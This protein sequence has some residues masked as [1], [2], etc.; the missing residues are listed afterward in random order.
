[1]KDMPL[2]YEGFAGTVVHDKA[3]FTAKPS[4]YFFHQLKDLS[5]SATREKESGARLFIGHYLCH[6]V[7]EARRMY[8][9]DRL[10]FYSEAEIEAQQVGA[11]GWLSGIADFAV[12]TVKGEGKIGIQSHV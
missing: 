4:D 9:L 1:M 12:A 10:V 11:L 8:G 3:L 5:L 7:K 2:L 6:A